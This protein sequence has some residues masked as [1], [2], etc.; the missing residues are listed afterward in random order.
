MLYENESYRNYL[1]KG[2]VEFVKETK[3]INN[4]LNLPWVPYVGKDYGKNGLPKLMFVGKSG[5]EDKLLIENKDLYENNSLSI[6]EEEAMIGSSNEFIQNRIMPHYEGTPTVEAKYLKENT[7]YYATFWKTIY[8]I[9]NGINNRSSIETYDNGTKGIF[10][11]IVWSN[12]FKI[13]DNQGILEND[14]R[15]KYMNYL[16]DLLYR[17]INILK[18]DIIFFSTGRD[19]DDVILSMLNNRE[20]NQIQLDKDDVRIATKYKGIQIYRTY[21]F[22]SENKKT[23][24]YL[25]EEL[26]KANILQ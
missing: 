15:N 9:T 7:R 25:S 3:S 23:L 4:S 5:C 14:L 13:S 17:E 2:L 24:E 26:K 8:Q 18:P 22:Q 20:G 10:D 1:F 19:L 6:A 11:T 12:L 16:G 21:H